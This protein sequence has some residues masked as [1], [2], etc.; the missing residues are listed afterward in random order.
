MRLLKKIKVN[1]YNCEVIFLITDNMLNSEKY[2]QKKYGGDP[3]PGTS[4]DDAEGLTITISGVLYVVMIDIK[5]LN[6]NTIAHELYHL[7][8]R[9]T[10]DRDITDEESSAWL[11]GFLAEEFYNFLSSKKTKK[12]FDSLTESNNGGESTKSTESTGS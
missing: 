5:Y 7:N 1:T 4:A 12:V 10:E 8:R 2:L 6:H 11:S 9:I 3:I